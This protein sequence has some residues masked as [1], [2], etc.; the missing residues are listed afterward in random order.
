MRFLDKAVGQNNA[1]S[2][3]KEIQNTCDIAALLSTDLKNSVPNKFGVGLPQLWSVGFQQCDSTQYFCTHFGVKGFQKIIYRTVA[4][5][6]M[7]EVYIVTFKAAALLYGIYPISIIC[8]ISYFVKGV[9]KIS[10]R[11]FTISS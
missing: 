10:S 1:L 3:V 11:Y 2:N 6:L 5:L 7:I 8:D 4:I 9:I